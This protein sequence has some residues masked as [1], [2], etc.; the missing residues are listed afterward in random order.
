M[1][2]NQLANIKVPVSSVPSEPASLD[3]AARTCDTAPT[4]LSQTAD[5]RHPAR[6]PKGKQVG[7]T[8]TVSGKL[9][10]P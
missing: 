8:H 6:L 1:F 2:V 4:Q 9:Q 5:R 7:Q 10:V 3:R